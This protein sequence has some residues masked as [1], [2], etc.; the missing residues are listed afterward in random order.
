MRT[1]SKVY[2]IRLGDFVEFRSAVCP[3]K[4]RVSKLTRTVMVAKAHVEEDEKLSKKVGFPYYKTVWVRV[5]TKKVMKQTFY[6]GGRVLGSCKYG[7]FVNRAKDY[8]LG[9]DKIIEV[10]SEI[11]ELC[12][13][14]RTNV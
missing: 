11:K 4:A 1:S 10:P 2:A 12:L 8:K 7:S 5:P 14:G 13:K 6:I 9:V 3:P